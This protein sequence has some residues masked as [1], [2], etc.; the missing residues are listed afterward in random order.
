MAADAKA[1]LDSLMGAD[2]N[3]GQ[4]R[5]QITAYDNDVC[6]FYTVWGEDP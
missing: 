6:P 3:S 1:L 5:R 2:R 4:D